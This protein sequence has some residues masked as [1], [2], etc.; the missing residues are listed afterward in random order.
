MIWWIVL[1]TVI[2]FLLSVVAFSAFDIPSF[3]HRGELVKYLHYILIGMTA[4]VLWLIIFWIGYESRACTQFIE[5]LGNVRRQWPEYLLD[6][7]VNETGVPRPYLD[8]YLDFQLVVAV[9][10]R[11]Q[12]LIY[13]PFVSILFMV[14][15]RSDLFDAMDFPL[16]LILI[17][18]VALLYTLYTAKLLNKSAGAMRAKVLAHY[19]QV[20]LQ[21]AQPRT[22]AQPPL[23]A[24]QI[25]RLIERIRNTREGAFASFAQQPALQ[26]L[27]LPFGGFGGAQLIDY[28]FTF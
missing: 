19:E 3:P 28:L 10:Q 12:W 25:N 4:P 9:T 13:L 20:L 7:E 11:I 17:V 1:S 23:S 8:Y 26:A 6:C 22:Q 15:A 16:A 5:A 21:L 24:E 27:L 2:V 14:I 18:I